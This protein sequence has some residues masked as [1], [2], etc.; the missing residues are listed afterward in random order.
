MRFPKEGEWYKL[1]DKPP[2]S[3]SCE[4]KFT[5]WIH[6]YKCRSHSTCPGERDVMIN[7]YLWAQN[8]EGPIVRL[9]DLNR[10]W[11]DMIVIWQVEPLLDE[12]EQ[13]LLSLVHR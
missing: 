10:L 8:G 6:V 5:L 2:R 4:G 12:S 9:G 13:V 1:L 3:W 7:A 11:S